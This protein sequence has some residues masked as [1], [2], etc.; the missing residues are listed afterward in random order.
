MDVTWLSDF[1]VLAKTGNFSRAAEARNVT[2]PA[3]SRRIRLLEDWVGTPLVDRRSH[4]VALTPAGLA[5]QPYAEDI[6]SRIEK[7]RQA[8]Q[9]SGAEESQ[10]LRF[11]TTQVLSLS[12][13]PIWLRSTAGRVWLGAV[14]LV[15]NSLVACEHMMLNSQAHFLLCH[16]RQGM[17]WQ[18]DEDQF[19]SILVRSDRLIPVSIPDENGRPVYDMD[20]DPEQVIPFLAYD[21]PA[22]LGRIMR[23]AFDP[24]SVRPQ[25]K[26]IA[27]SHL[28]LLL[29]L[30]LEGR[31]V[32]WVPENVVRSELDQNHICEAGGTRWSI[33]MEIRL[34]RSRN[35]LGPRAEAFWDLVSSE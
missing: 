13:F 11:A 9:D 10:T 35:D 7:G 3:F 32:A 22:G 17:P 14:N 5:F 24:E 27:E 23:S 31:G 21:G 4:P 34:F 18:L 26:P 19:T 6:L 29:G 25:L 12:Y 15:S 16:Y 1:T 33:P 8:A 20:G 28:A 30:A 2:Q